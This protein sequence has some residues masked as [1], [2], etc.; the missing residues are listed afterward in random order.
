VIGGI[1]ET[2]EM[3]TFCGENGIGS[4]VEV[5]PAQKINEAYERTIKGDVRY[6]FVIDTAS[7]K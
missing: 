2:Q 1:A 3:L 6:R 4:D 7:L 5:I